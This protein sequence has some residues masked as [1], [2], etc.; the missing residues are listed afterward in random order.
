MKMVGEEGEVGLKSGRRWT[1]SHAR[2]T[3]LN[4]Q[5]RGRDSTLRKSRPEQNTFF[6]STPQFQ[7]QQ[8]QHRWQY[9]MA[10][11][12]R[13]GS[14]SAGPS[15]SRRFPRTRAD[16]QPQSLDFADEDEAISSGVE[17]EERGERSAYGPK[18]LRAYQ[19]ALECYLVFARRGEEGANAAYNAA[20]VLHILA[21]GFYMPKRAYRALREA[22]ELY[23]AA[24]TTARGRVDRGGDGDDAAFALD[25]ASNLAATMQSLVEVMTNHPWVTGDPDSV[26][27]Q[28]VAL[29]S[30]AIALLEDVAQEQEKVLAAQLRDEQQGDAAASV[31]DESSTTSN[32]LPQA[33][34]QD[35]TGAPSSP[36]YTSSLITPSS[37]LETLSTLHALYLSSLLPHSR[38]A[39]DVQEVSRRMTTILS[40]AQ[41]FVATCEA[42][43]GWG[44]RT[45]PDEEWE[46]GLANLQSGSDEADVSV[47][48]QMA[49]L[50][51]D[52]EDPTTEAAIAE[53]TLR[54]GRARLTSMDAQLKNK[55]AL[56]EAAAKLPAARRSG[57]WGRKVQEM[58]EWGE[59][60]V[61]LARL[62]LRL[63]LRAQRRSGDGNT[64][65]G[66][67]MLRLSFSLSTI[68]YQLYL[69]LS[70]LLDTTSPSSG[71]A[72]VLGS[73]TSL[74]PT[75]L[76]RADIFT[77]LAEV[78]LLRSHLAFT[79][80]RGPAV[81]SDATRGTMQDNARVYARKALQQVGLDW[82]LSAGANGEKAMQQRLLVTERRGEQ[83]PP[84]GFE[85]VE[86]MAQALLVAARAALHRKTFRP[87]GAAATAGQEENAE[88]LALA[89]AVKALRHGRDRPGAVDDDGETGDW[90]SRQGWR[91]ALDPQAWWEALADEE[92]AKE[93]GNVRV[94]EEHFWRVE[95]ARATQI[96]G[97]E[98][99]DNEGE[100]M[101]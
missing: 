51:S 58:S 91:V 33:T 79:T 87:T 14:S 95:W 30:E 72:A 98:G 2:A 86:T 45:S 94:E 50:L 3:L 15:T 71:A 84:R 22:R 85:A 61:T 27:Q 64:A 92:C 67:E 39:T 96:E 28:V 53:E 1:R 88:L 89:M 26:G 9:P 90:V 8:Q 76:Q 101:S 7:Q 24:L 37:L 49:S 5:D 12:R 97:E 77:S 99:G 19:S 69:Y 41:E 65:E 35:A 68:T 62:L 4:Q 20:R 34:S 60:A 29:A 47:L 82:V 54:L 21:D 16:P 55:A 78:S 100:T 48:G 44:T 18:A 80:L 74:S 56:S 66:D 75:S 38:T 13:Q 36:T 81:V 42:A 57:F 43:N 40:R 70:S 63:A 23:G 32:D 6:H 46:S 83:L 73:S 31:P 93:E 10:T 17:H 25:V 59:Q 11:S 52:D